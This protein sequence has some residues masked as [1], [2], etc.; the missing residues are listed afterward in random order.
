MLRVRKLPQ[1]IHFTDNNDLS[2]RGLPVEWGPGT[3]G[4]SVHVERLFRSI[5]DISLHITKVK[6]RVLQSLKT[7]RLFAHWPSK[8]PQIL[9]IVIVKREQKNKMRVFVVPK[10]LHLETSELI[11]LRA[12][13]DSGDIFVN[14]IIVWGLMLEEYGRTIKL[15]H[16]MGDTRLCV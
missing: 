16:W 4:R 15:C 6:P 5:P 7:T 9:A 2:P 14:N 13:F 3:S 8:F 1:V 12:C 11:D 10:L